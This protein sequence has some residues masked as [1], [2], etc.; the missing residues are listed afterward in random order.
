MEL[1]VRK[2]IKRTIL[3]SSGAVVLFIAIVALLYYLP[4]LKAGANSAK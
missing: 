4:T 2:R 1:L 3:I